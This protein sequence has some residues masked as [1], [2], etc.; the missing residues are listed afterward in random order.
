MFGHRQVPPGEQRLEPVAREQRLEAVAR[1]HLAFVWRVLRRL[2]LS[3]ADADDATQKVLL[4][5]ARR[6]DDIEPG[7]ER[8]FLSRTATYIALKSRR[9]EERRREDPLLERDGA[10]GVTPNPE[11][12]VARRRTLATLDSLLLELPMELRTP[13][14]L[15]EIEGMS[16]D[17]IALALDIPRGTVGSRL[18][19]A[20]ERLARL[21]VIR[22]GKARAGGGAT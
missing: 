17:E 18:R 20:R 3:T 11:E 2:G 15:F 8:A 16:Q 1:E 6:L 9:T 21:V 5:V 19:R 13:F 22:R 4:T 12:L 14:V 7:R 10:E